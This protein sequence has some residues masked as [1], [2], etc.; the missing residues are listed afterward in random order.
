MTGKYTPACTISI[1]ETL[2][3]QKSEEMNLVMLSLANSEIK[4]PFDF[5][6]HLSYK[7]KIL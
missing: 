2:I 1:N 7:R 4:A 5:A 3:L 6:V